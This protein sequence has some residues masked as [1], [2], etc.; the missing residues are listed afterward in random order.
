MKSRRWT[1]KEGI[2][3]IKIDKEWKKGQK[4]LDGTEKDRRR[5][6]EEWTERD[7]EE[8]A[9]TERDKEGKKEEEEIHK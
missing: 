6:G 9:G 1:K 8:K 7:W 5:G 2:K 4:E 3:R